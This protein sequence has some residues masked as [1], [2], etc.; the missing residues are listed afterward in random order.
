MENLINQPKGDPLLSRLQQLYEEASEEVRNEY[1]YILALSYIH[2]D[3][4]VEG[5]VFTKN[6]LLDA[7]QGKA[8]TDASLQP[9]YDEA[10]H[11]RAAL[12]MVR[13][14]AKKKG[15]KLTAE[16][17]KDI[18]L[19]LA[20]EEVDGKKPPAFR[21]DMPLH[22]S[23]FHE[24]STP[25][26]IQ[27]KLKQLIDWVNDPETRKTT[28]PVRLASKAHHLFMHVYPYPKHNG[29]IGRF[30]L[31]YL[32]LRE[33]YPPAVLHE[34]DRQKYYEAL[35]SSDNVT[36][37]VVK[38]ALLDSIEA[39]IK[40]FEMKNPAKIE[41]PKKKKVSKPLPTV[42]S[43][44]PSFSAL[45]AESMRPIPSLPTPSNL[46]SVPPLS[47]TP[48]EGIDVSHSSIK[49]P[50]IKPAVQPKS[51]KPVGKGSV[52]PASKAAS[53]NPRSPKAV[54]SKSK[55]PASTKKSST[56]PSQKR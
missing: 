53:E 20:P 10:K 26:K 44:L 31:N 25:D 3:S 41:K 5:I 7:Y 15:N 9:L 14:E 43:Q 39:G 32:L 17:I 55:A 52:P 46:I 24:I 47:R 29:R 45:Q 37:Q 28:H 49:L 40:F 35:K 21:K 51:A 54:G 38:E 27:L 36:A 22:R 13:N 6:E 42:Q 1:A 12:E 16:F 34:T 30:L 48:V 50:S 56:K 18:Y 2:H 11:A 8:P 4:A 23:Y 19:F 33:G